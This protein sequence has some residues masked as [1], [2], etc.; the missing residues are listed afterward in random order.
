MKNLSSTDQLT[1]IKAKYSKTGFEKY[2]EI[3]TLLRVTTAEGE[4]LYYT[5]YYSTEREAIN[6]AYKFLNPDL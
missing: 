2:N 5:Q 6:D 1:W 4:D 3:E